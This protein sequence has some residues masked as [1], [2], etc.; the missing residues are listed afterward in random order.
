MQK[1]KVY[2]SLWAMERR[3]TDGIEPSLLDNLERIHAAGYDGVGPVCWEDCPSD[4]PTSC[5]IGCAISSGDCAG[6]TLSGFDGGPAD[7]RTGNVVATNGA[8]HAELLEVLHR[9]E[10]ARSG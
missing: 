4:F 10:Q 2:Q 6:G 8:I 7:V 1:F 5:G 9:V 3:H